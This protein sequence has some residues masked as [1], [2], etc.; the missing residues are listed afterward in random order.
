MELTANSTALPSVPRGNR[1][2][3]PNRFSVAS[4]L[5]QS[6]L[7]GLRLAKAVPVSSLPEFARAEKLQVDPRCPYT[8]AFLQKHREYDN[9][10]A[11]R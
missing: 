1:S 2:F 8:A 7:S 11:S 3:T 9:L 5:S 4:T 6:T 10:L